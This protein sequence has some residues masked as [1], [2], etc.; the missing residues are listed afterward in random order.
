MLIRFLLAAFIFLSGGAYADAA[1]TKMIIDANVYQNNSKAITGSGLNF[2]LKD[3]V[4]Y[5]TSATTQISASNITVSGTATIGV[6]SAT[7]F[8]SG[9]PVALPLSFANEVSVMSFGAKGDGVTNDSAAF[10]AASAWPV[11]SSITSPA[12]RF[13]WND[14]VTLQATKL[15]KFNGAFF[16]A[17]AITSATTVSTSAITVVAPPSASSTYYSHFGIENFTLEGNSKDSGI[18][19]ITFLTHNVVTRNTTVNKFRRA[20]VYQSE[21]YIIDNYNAAL[22]RS[23]VGI[24]MAGGFV[25]YGEK[26]SYFGGVIA[27]NESGF[28]MGNTNGDIYLINVSNDYNVAVPLTG[29]APQWGQVDA[30]RVHAVENH[31]E[32]NIGTLATPP[33]K[34]SNTN[35]AG[36]FFTGGII[37]SIGSNTNAS[38]TSII[39]IGQLGIAQFKGTFLHNLGLV[40][41]CFKSGAGK[42]YITDTANYTTA[43]MG[44]C[45][46]QGVSS[47]ENLMLD[48]GFEKAALPLA[49]LVWISNDSGPVYSQVSGTNVSITINTGSSV[50]GTQSLKITKLGG[51]GT[52]AGVKIAVPISY[53]NAMTAGSFFTEKPTTQTGQWFISPQYARV[54]YIASNTIPVITSTSTIGTI[55]VAST[56]SPTAWTA[57]TITSIAP[58]SKAPTGMTHFVIDLNLTSLGAGDIN[59]D[60]VTLGKM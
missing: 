20:H 58:T 10:N 45:V 32:T 33:I 60:N 57:R 17:T 51:A 28:Y 26:I 3:M 4:D 52:A 39:D 9:T 35:G 8:V 13:K 30:G 27:G 34:V 40:G 43:L 7:Y 23:Q 12:Y 16:D 53:P 1:T 55:T 42:L 37:T 5:T 54:Q 18:D 25:N 59:I 29:T 49:D 47:T 38:P 46:S 19:G 14:P 2:T 36:L 22:L 41:G 56:A 21:A 15:Y 50:S 48:G 24:Y 6:I 11:S 44:N 31:W